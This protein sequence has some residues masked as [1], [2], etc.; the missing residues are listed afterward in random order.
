M[1][2]A[3]RGDVLSIYLRKLCIYS[4]KNAYKM[5]FGHS[6]AWQITGVLDLLSI[7]LAKD[8]NNTGLKK[9]YQKF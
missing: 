5:G 8:D 7:V 2:I 3:M 1:D 9:Q 6:K 4:E